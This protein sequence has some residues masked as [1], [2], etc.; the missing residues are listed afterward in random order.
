MI[1]GILRQIQGWVKIKGGTD[2]SI[3]GN[4]GDRIKVESASDLS[5]DFKVTQLYNQNITLNDI[6]Y[7]DIATFTGVHT[8]SGFMVQFNSN[9][10]YTRLEIDG[11]EIFDILNSELQVVS[12]WDKAAQP[13]LYISWNSGTNAFFFTPNFPITST[14]SIKIQS[15]AS[16][17]TGQ[18]KKYISSLIQVN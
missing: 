5:S 17:G 15:R 9:S 13:P 4:T 3:I 12:D 14:S 2:G 10:T 11:V 18:A 6:T 1:G 8:V 16:N 7:T